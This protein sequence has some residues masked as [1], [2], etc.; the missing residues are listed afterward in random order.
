VL[1]GITL[2]VI[3]TF[4]IFLGMLIGYLFNTKQTVT[5]AAISTGIVLL[6]FSNT[7]LPLETLSKSSRAIVSYNPFVIGEGLLKKILLFSLNI[8]GVVEP[9]VILGIF[10]AILFVGIIA[11]RRFSQQ[12]VRSE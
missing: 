12:S 3:G 7:I 9:L 8:T 4:F 6:F 11:A 5:L 2:L 10:C 1:A